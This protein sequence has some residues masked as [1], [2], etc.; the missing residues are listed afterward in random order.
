M[1]KVSNPARRQVAKIQDYQWVF[2]TL[3]GKNILIDLMDAHHVLRPTY[4]KDVNEALVLEGERRVVL[5]IL[6]LL[7]TNPNTLL[8]RIEENEKQ[9]E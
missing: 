6:G 5:R 4:T 1:K 7:K 9:M 8:Q 2:N 3:Q